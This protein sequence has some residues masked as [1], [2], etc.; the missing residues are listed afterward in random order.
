M[1]KAVDGI[2][3]RGVADRNGY[4]VV[5]AG[6]RNGAVLSGNVTADERNDLVGRAYVAEIDHFSAEVCGFGLGNI[7]R[8]HHLVRQHKINGAHPR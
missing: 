1:M 3:V 7:R 8:P 5:M 6:N 4:G 2:Q